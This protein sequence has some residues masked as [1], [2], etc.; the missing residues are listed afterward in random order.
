MEDIV[1]VA[2][3]LDP[4]EGVES[5]GSEQEEAEAEPQHQGV[6]HPGQ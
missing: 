5:E 6:G 4:E 1:E 2:R 3:P